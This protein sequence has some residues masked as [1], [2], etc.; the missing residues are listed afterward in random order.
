MVLTWPSRAYEILGLI[1]GERKSVE[2]ARTRYPDLVE[3]EDNIRIPQNVYWYFLM[4]ALIVLIGRPA[5]MLG[6]AWLAA[7]DQDSR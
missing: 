6:T 3:S 2:A 5:S 4:N 1:R 7:L